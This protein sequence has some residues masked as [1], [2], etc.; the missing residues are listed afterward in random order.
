MSERGKLILSLMNGKFKKGR[1][2]F[3]PEG[4]YN[5]SSPDRSSQKN[6]PSELRGNARPGAGSLLRGRKGAFYGIKS[7]SAG[8]ADSGDSV[9]DFA[10]G[11]GLYGEG[12]GKDS[13]LEENEEGG[14]L[15]EEDKK[16]E[17]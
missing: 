2:S 9:G 15:R 12:G 13:G 6:L 7:Q 8:E 14:G 5:V 1:V 17:Q 4:C 3:W 11:P 10:G 16:A